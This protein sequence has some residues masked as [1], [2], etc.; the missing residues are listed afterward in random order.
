MSYVEVFEDR[1]VDLLYPDNPQ[2][3]QSQVEVNENGHVSSATNGVGTNN[4]LQI[5]MNRLTGPYVEDLSTV[6]V[7][8]LQEAQ[9]LLND[10]VRVSNF[11]MCV[12][13]GAS[14]DFEMQL[15]HSA[16]SS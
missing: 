11:Y 6:A 13:K 3:Y 10:T 2:H 12:H 1:V 14:I 16:L 5:R 9:Q 8:S 4:G 7:Q 15:V